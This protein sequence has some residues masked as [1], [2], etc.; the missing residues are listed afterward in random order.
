MPAMGQPK[1]VFNLLKSIKMY[2]EKQV[3]TFI[4]KFRQYRNYQAKLVNLRTKGETNP[5][6][7]NIKPMKALLANIGG[8]VKELDVL[9]NEMQPLNVKPKKVLVKGDPAGMVN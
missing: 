2:D 3:K 7:E 6:R 4:K 9:A 5:G 8:L 1:T